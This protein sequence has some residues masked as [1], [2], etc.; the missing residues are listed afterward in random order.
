M[1]SRECID[2]ELI[3]RFLD[4]LHDLLIEAYYSTPPYI[5]SKTL[6]KRAKELVQSLLLTIKR[7]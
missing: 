7:E 6:I 4:Q 2:R 1:S 5:S 3:E